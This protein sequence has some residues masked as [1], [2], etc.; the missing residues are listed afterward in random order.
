MGKYVE[1]N[2]E[3][4]E[5]IVKKAELNFLSLLGA[6]IKG[7]LFFWVLFIPTIKAIVAT[8]KFFNIELALTNK[9]IIGKTGVLSTDALNAPLDKIQNVGVN[10]TLFGRMFNYGTVT[11]NTA[12]GNYTFHMIKNVNAFKGQI[13][14]QIEI[15]QE[16]KIQLQAEKMAS[17][18]A[19]AINK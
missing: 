10:Q 3:R 4:N 6:W 14:S 8:L 12:A 18:M 11:I 1:N 7:I 16:E 17:A 9:R 2:L 5:N 19:S 15:Y 13:M